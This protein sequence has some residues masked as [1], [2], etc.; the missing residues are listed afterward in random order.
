MTLGDGGLETEVQA[1]AETE[2][3]F[4]AVVPRADELIAVTRAVSAPL[5]AIDFRRERF[6]GPIL[7]L[8]CRWR[9]AA[10]K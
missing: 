9:T 5:R 6:V 3:G 7:T 8:K 4:P 1:I 10:F 2:P